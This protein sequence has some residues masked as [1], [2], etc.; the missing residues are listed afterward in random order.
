VGEGS[1]ISTSIA[2][3]RVSSDHSRIA[4]AGRKIMKIHG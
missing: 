2:P 3:E 1:V 4:I